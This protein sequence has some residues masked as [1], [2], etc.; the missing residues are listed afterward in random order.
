MDIC[1]END[2]IVVGINTLGAEIIS[3]K[4]KSSKEEY[5]WCGDPS[6]WAGHAPVLFPVVGGLVD[7]QFR[8]GKKTYEMKKHGFARKSEFKV[9]SHDVSSAVFRLK[10]NDETLEQYPFYFCL[11]IA[12]EL[13]GS[14]VV[15]DYKVRNMDDKDMPFQLGTH[16]S[17]MINQSTNEGLKDWVI[18]FDQE[19]TLNR[20]YITSTLVDNTKEQLLGENCQSLRVKEEDFYEDALVFKNINSKVITL[21]SEKTSNYVQLT[22]VNLPDLGI[23]QPKDAPFLCIEPWAGT[24]DEVGFN[25]SFYDKHNAIT[26]VP[27]D[28]FKAQ[29]AIEIG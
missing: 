10:A 7:G 5:V 12:Y 16:T 3:M 13:Q 23:W 21:K 1:L 15:I 25:G 2:D 8:I 20:L 11:E 14:S 22:S 9:I 18:N 27:R 29:L 28:K 6:Y 26:L 24:G 17:F 19:E 4:R